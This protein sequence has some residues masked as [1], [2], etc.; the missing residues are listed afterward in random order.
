MRCSRILYQESTMLKL[1]FECSS[2]R[3]QM[4]LY[5]TI[6]VGWGARFYLEL[7]LTAAIEPM[8]YTVFSTS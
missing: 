7:L 8:A 5:I 4:S 1:I 2:H 3:Q 6:N